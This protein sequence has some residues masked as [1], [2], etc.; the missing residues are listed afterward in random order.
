MRL[1]EARDAPLFHGSPLCN[2]IRVVSDDRLQLNQ[3]G[4]ISLSRSYHVARY[5]QE[6]SDFPGYGGVLV[7]DQAKLSQRYRVKPF[8]DQ[9]N[10][11]FESFYDENEE[12]VFQPIEPL[13]N[14][15]LSILIDR[16]AIKQALTDQHYREESE[17]YAKAFDGRRTAFVA[18]VRA[19]LRHPAVNRW[20]PRLLRPNTSHMQT[21]G[22]Y[23]QAHPEDD[24]EPDGPQQFRAIFVPPDHDM[25][26]MPDP[27]TSREK[28]ITANSGK[29]AREIAERFAEQQGYRLD[30][31]FSSITPG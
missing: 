25:R 7:L 3:R 29:E 1:V 6:Y 10:L 30:S 16:D 22:D 18:G 8:H 28:I 11:D 19:L 12:R 14:Y 5:F 24:D 4:F 2:L 17:D 9:H 31:I 21:F 27:N 23:I 13:S 15:L 26:R 20:R